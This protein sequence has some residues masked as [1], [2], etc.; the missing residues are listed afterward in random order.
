MKEVKA[1]GGVTIVQDPKTAEFAEM[2]R[3]A[4]KMVEIDHVLPLNKITEMLIH[5]NSSR[6]LSKRR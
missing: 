3:S 5:L 4:I 6:V 2:P 1:C